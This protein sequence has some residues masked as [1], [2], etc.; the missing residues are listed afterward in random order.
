[1]TVEG[2][3]DDIS[4]I[5]QTQAAHTLC[6]NIPK[7]MRI[8]HV[9]EGV[10][11]YGVFNGYRFREQIVPKLNAF[12]HSHFDKKAEQTLRSKSKNIDLPY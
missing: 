12:F 11:H 4:G 2:E 1:M 5:G 3:L 9:Q 6:S 8:D 7:A 10:G